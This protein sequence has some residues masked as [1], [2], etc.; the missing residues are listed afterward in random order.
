MADKPMTVIT[1]A[2]VVLLIAILLL[3]FLSI[4]AVGCAQS[5]SR[6]LDVVETKPSSIAEAEAAVGFPIVVPSFLPARVGSNPKIFVASDEHRNEL[7]L[8]YSENPTACSGG[9]GTCATIHESEIQE[10][11]GRYLPGTDRRVVQVDG[12]DVELA[13]SMPPISRPQ[14]VA[15]WNRDGVAFQASFEWMSAGEQ[16]FP[17]P[18][19]EAEA[20]KVIES[21]ISSVR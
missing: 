14:L 3:F 12:V 8:L 20:L 21:M 9:G 11:E 2:A 6:S 5:D 10:G 1:R 16:E 7:T 13:V 19:Q 15:V 18:A 4:V 17:T